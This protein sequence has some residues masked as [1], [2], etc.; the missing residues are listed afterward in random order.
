M[1]GTYFPCASLY[2]LPEQREGA[3]VT[4]NF[5]EG[6]DAILSGPGSKTSRSGSACHRVEVYVA[7]SFA[8]CYTYFR[9]YGTRQG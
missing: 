2:T 5:G 1:E 4:F 7:L 9:R 8:L 6:P 3:T